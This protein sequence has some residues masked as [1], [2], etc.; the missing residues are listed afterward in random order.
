[1]AVELGVGGVHDHHGR[2]V[3][4]PEVVVMVV[5]QPTHSA[6]GLFLRGFAGHGA[7]GFQAVVERQNAAGGL[8]HMLG[9]QT[10]GLVKVVMNLLEH[11]QT[12]SQQHQHGDYQNQPQPPAD[13]HI[14]Q[15]VHRPVTPGFL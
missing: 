5:A 15:T 11:Q 8:Y 13:R 10:F 2:K 4:D 3:V 7:G 6:E 12:Q 14:A 1:L 9:L